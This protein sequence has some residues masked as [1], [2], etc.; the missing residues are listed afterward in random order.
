MTGVTLLCKFCGR[1][2][3]G[4]PAKYGG[5]G[6]P[7]HLECTM[8]PA[9]FGNPTSYAY[10]AACKAMWHWRAEAERLGAIAG[11]K[12]RQMQHD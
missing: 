9:S 1:P 7:Y 4:S 8:P 2:I 12:P 11:E 3:I 5:S 10:E 6:E